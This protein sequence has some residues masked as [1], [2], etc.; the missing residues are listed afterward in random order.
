MAPQ[1]IAPIGL[2]DSGTGIRG[3]CF[4]TGFCPS[5]SAPRPVLKHNRH[6]PRLFS[7]GRPSTS[8]RLGGRKREPS[9]SG[10]QHC[11]VNYVKFFLRFSK[12]VA[13]SCF[14]GFITSF[15]LNLLHYE[16]CSHFSCTY[17]VVARSIG[18]FSAMR[19]NRKKI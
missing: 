2:A 9:D 1:E 15:C 14:S 8:H 11:E 18:N 12:A 17:F 3:I 6:C 13:S 16:M 4:W 5:S 10:S 19:M 7:Q